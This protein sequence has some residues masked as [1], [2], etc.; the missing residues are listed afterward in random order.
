MTRDL[1]YVVST[2]YSFN[3]AFRKKRFGCT[4]FFL[5]FSF[6]VDCTVERLSR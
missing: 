5:F 1:R 6:F 2:S 4:F 3:L